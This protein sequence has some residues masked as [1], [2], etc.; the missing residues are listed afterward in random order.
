MRAVAPNLTAIADDFGFNAK[1]RDEKLGGEIS[2]AFF[3]MGGPVSPDWHSL[4]S[5]ERDDISP[6]SVS[7][8][9]R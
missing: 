1:Q 2:L 6:L 5:C 4:L 3:V 8:I 7:E 9:D